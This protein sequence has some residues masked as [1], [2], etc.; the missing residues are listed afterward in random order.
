MIG[1]FLG[2][3]QAPNI[4]TLIEIFI[5]AALK[6]TISVATMW[7]MRASGITGELYLL[8]LATHYVI[9]LNVLIARYHETLHLDGLINKLIHDGTIDRAEPP[10]FYLRRDNQRTLTDDGVIS[11]RLGGRTTLEAGAE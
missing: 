6:V 10:Q 4:T 2:L 9:M 1:S 3:T 7:F 8:N 5:K 11:E